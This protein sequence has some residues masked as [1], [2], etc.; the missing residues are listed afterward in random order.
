M[1]RTQHWSMVD[2][3]RWRSSGS[4]KCELTGFVGSE[5][6]SGRCNRESSL[7]GSLPAAR[8]GGVGAVTDW[9]WEGTIGG[10]G[11]R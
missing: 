3:R 2:P 6:S 1:D 8:T 7:R 9:Q 4:P 11:V 5:R 10:G